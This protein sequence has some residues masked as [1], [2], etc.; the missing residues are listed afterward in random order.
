MN[1][2][3][4]DYGGGIWGKPFPQ[5]RTGDGLQPPRFDL[6]PF[7]DITFSTGQRW[8]VKGLLASTGLATIFGP[9][10]QYKSFIAGDLGLHIAAGRDWAGRKVR[11]GAVVYI[12]AEGATGFTDRIAANRQKFDYPDDLPF[13]L[14][15]AKPNLGIGEGDTTALILAIE[16]VIQALDIPLAA[17]FI[18]TLVR[19]LSGSSENDE[20]MRNFTDNAEVIADHFDCLTVAIHHCGKDV[21]KGMRGSSALHG[22][23]VSSWKVEKSKP[24]QACITL[25]DAKDGESGLTWT[26]DLERYVYGHD[27]DGDEA[28]V[29]VVSHIS[30][31]ISDDAIGDKGKPSSKPAS[32]PAQLR[33]LIACL[34]EAM[35]SVGRIAQPY[36][37]GPKIRVVS[38][39]AVRNAYFAKRGDE[40]KADTKRK[41]FD[42]SLKK[43]LEQRLLIVETINDDLVVWKARAD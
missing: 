37:D 14:I 27:E 13:F 18:D 22:A 41:A 36:H 29:L 34:E 5:T 16:P 15:S 38:V 4:I 25:E 32:V 2:G 43:G 33:L 11:Q 3:M 10:K 35:G 17:V 42:Y 40:T 6:I 19:T 20:G 12:V 28:S 24:F 30:D 31:P 39:D 21:T 1:S 8:L 7:A 23:V 9:P 26:A